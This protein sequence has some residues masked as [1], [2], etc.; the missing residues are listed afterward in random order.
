MIGH[1]AT[2]SSFTK[3]GSEWLSG[4]IYSWKVQLGIGTGC[5]VKAWSHHPWQYLKDVLLWFLGTWFNSGLDRARLM[6][7]FDDLKDLFRSK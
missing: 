6:V 7:G 2:A 4:G 3:E 5:P 1:D